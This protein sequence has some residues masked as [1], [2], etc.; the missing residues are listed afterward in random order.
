MLASGM[1]QKLGKSIF[2]SNLNTEDLSR[3]GIVNGIDRAKA[4]ALY[5]AR[6]DDS[7]PMYVEYQ[8]IKY[9]V[10]ITARFVIE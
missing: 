1:G 9:E 7:G 6:A 10:K 8:K 3:Q 5:G 2:I 4:T